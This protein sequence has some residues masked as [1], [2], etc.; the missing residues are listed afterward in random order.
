MAS[1]QAVTVIEK[2][3]NNDLISWIFPAVDANTEQTLK[4]RSGLNSNS[5][6]PPF[7]F[8]RFGNTWQ[9]IFVSPISDLKNAKV[10]SI[11]VCVLTQDFNPPKYKAL[12]GIFSEMYTAEN[13][14]MPIMKAYLQVVTTGKVNSEHGNF[15][16][17]SFDPRRALVSPVKPLFE[18]F[19]VEII[20]IWVAMVL[21]K[22][23]FV[24]ADS[25]TELQAAVRTLP[26]LGCW[27]RQNWD[28]LRPFMNVDE[29]EMKDLEK[30]GVYVAGFTDPSCASQTKHYDLFLD[31]TARS[32]TIAEHAEK[33]FMM[34]KYHKQTAEALC[35]IAAEESD[36]GAIKG[37]AMK[38]AELISNIEKFKTEQEDGTYV[39]LE[40]L[41][42]RNLPPNMDKFLYNVALAEKMCS[43]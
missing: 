26:L 38:T 29:T 34:S 39:T 32:Y 19:G 21:K 12:L 37:I 35:K 40:T 25:L 5:S 2:D 27:H 10:M 31:I 36:Q 4:N 6:G 28:I 7:R 30:L 43:P 15:E 17:A 14:P 11:A 3:V 13:S 1:L 33:E 9:Y 42:S 8:S 16:D 22:R 18:M 41:Q 20:V 24:Y 23:V